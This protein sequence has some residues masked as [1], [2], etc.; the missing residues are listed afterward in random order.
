MSKMHS[1]YQPYREWELF[2]EVTI[3]NISF[4]NNSYRLPK[5]CIIY[6]TRDSQFDLKATIT[7]V[8]E[9]PQFLDSVAGE[10]SGTVSEH[11]NIYGYSI[12]GVFKYK[13]HGIVIGKHSSYPVS[14]D[15]PSIRFEAELLLDSFQKFY[16]DPDKDYESVQDWFLSGKTEISFSRTTQRA[17]ENKYIKSR[18]E[19]DPEEVTGIT[20]GRG[21]SR[22]FLFV[23]TS[24]FDCI[25]GHVP[26]EFGPDWS[27]N[28]CIEY[29]KAFK[30][31]PTEN[32]RE[33]VKELV[34][35]IFGT[36]LLHIGST[37]YGAKSETISQDIKN[38]WGDNV[39]SKCTKGSLPPADITKFN[40]NQAEILLN[41]LLP[42]YLKL[43]ERLRLSGAIW[44]YWIARYSSIGTNLPI[45][46]SA[47]ETLS[48]FIL[49]EHKEVKHYYIEYG[50]FQKLIEDELKSI[51]EKLSGHLFKEKVLNK[52][53]SASQ[54]GSNEKVEMM[55][56]IIDLKVGEVERKA[57][58]A[59]NKMA[60]SSFGKIDRDEAI[61]LIRTTRAYETLFHRVFLKIL[62]YK[63][64]YIDY[65]TLSNPHRNI[66]EAIPE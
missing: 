50:E 29:R 18:M 4:E 24:E 66:N 36:Q 12:D 33:A 34:S 30:R 7:G 28:L 46:S 1:H 2:E 27:F 32:E 21:S 6:I 42:E 59:R 55:F 26:K 23:T 57:M 39:V 31:I 53:R 49:K 17:V 63:G 41:T 37:Y 48:E 51:N 22:D 25:V 38:P 8:I 52:I 16:Y 40:K 65:Y 15:P 64:Q 47:I 45:L 54:R 58:K 3:T 44:K 20:S 35:F 43:R 10:I 5:E 56:E 62:G 9:N 60:H 11:E 14:L 19:I 13:L 61:S